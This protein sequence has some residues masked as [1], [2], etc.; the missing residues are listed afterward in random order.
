MNEGGSERIL[1]D[2]KKKG[3]EKKLGE[4]KVGPS[5]D[6]MEFWI[7]SIKKALDGVIETLQHLI[8]K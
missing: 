1:V 4:A 2:T 5:F 7:T 8:G 3:L 6:G